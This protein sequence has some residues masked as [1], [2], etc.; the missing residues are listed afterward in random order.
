M[1]LFLVLSIFV[2][3][4]I[5]VKSQGCSSEQFQCD[6]GECIDKT[7]V[8]D[9]VTDC[10][11]ESLPGSDERDCPA[12]SCD[13]DEYQCPDGICI[14]SSFRCDGED[15]CSDGDDEQTC[16]GS[17]CSSEEYPCDNGYCIPSKFRCDRVEDCPDGSDEGTDRCTYPGCIDQKCDNGACYGAGERCDGKLD[18]RDGT[19]E[20]NCTSIRCQSGQ[21]QCDNGKCIPQA[22][23]CDVWNNCGDRSDEPD[24]CVYDDCPGDTFTCDNHVCVNQD[25]V[26]DGIDNC[27]DGTDEQGCNYDLVCLNNQWKCTNSS[28]CIDVVQICDGIKDCDNGEDESRP[29]TPDVCSSTRCGILSCDYRCHATLSGG[30]CYCNQGYQVADDMVSCE[31]FDECSVFGVC[32]QICENTV[33]SYKCECADGYVK[34]LHNNHIHC[35]AKPADGAPKLLYSVGKNILTYH[36]ETNAQDI[37]VTDVSDFPLGVDYHYTQGKL[38]WADTTLNKIMSSDM[39]GGQATTVL[40]VSIQNPE[41]VA[42]DW[43]ANNLYIIETLVS[44]IEV[45]NF[46]GSHRSSIIT[47]GIKSPR[48]LALDPTKGYMFFTDYHQDSPRLDR[49]YMDGSQ[50]YTLVDTEMGVPSGVAVDYVSSRV[51]WVDSKFDYLETVDYYGKDRRVVL[52]GSSSLPHPFDVTIFEDH[53]YVSD[54]TKLAILKANKFDGSEMETVTNTGGVKPMG[55]KAIHPVRQPQ[56]NNPCETQNGGCEHLCVLSHTSDNNGL[57]YSCLCDP[58]YVINVDGKTCS[59]VKSFLLVDNYDAIRGITVWRFQRPDAIL[60]ILSD[61]QYF[62]GTTADAVDG[63]IYFADAARSIV[64]RRFMNATGEQEDIINNR[65]SSIRSIAIDWTTKNLYVIDIGRRVIEVV[66]AKDPENLRKTIVSSG[67]SSPTGIALSPNQGY[68]VWADVARPAK[69]VKAWMDGTHQVPLVNTTLYSPVSV[70]IDLTSNYVYWIDSRFFRIERISLFGYGRTQ[71]STTQ[72][73]VYPSALTFFE[74]YVYWSD[75]RL[76][77]IYRLHELAGSFEAQAETVREGIP[78][79]YS[80]YYYDKDLQ[81]RYSSNQCTRPELPNGGCQKFCFPA[82]SQ[83][84]TCGCPDGFM[85]GVTGTTCVPD[86]HSTPP[87]PCTEYQF[88]CDNGRCVSSSYVCNGMDDCKDGSDEKDC[89]GTCGPYAFK[90]DNNQ[91]IY[92]SWKCDG[93]DDCGDNSDEVG[94]PTPRPCSSTS[95]QCDNGRCI[96]PTWVCDSTNDCGDG[97]DEKDCESQTC[98]PQQFACDDQRCISS[99]LRCNGYEDC[100]QGEDEK[101]CPP[102]SCDP[103]YYFACSNGVQCIGKS[104]KCDG[105]SDC[106]DGSDEIGCPTLH[107]GQCEND[108]FQC[109]SNGVCI[110]QTWYCDSRIDCDDGSDEPPTCPVKEC[111]SYEFR[112]DNNLCI[113]SI[114]KCNGYNNCGDGSDEKDCPTPPPTLPPPPCGFNEWECPGTTQCIEYSKVCNGLSDCPDALDEGDFCSVNRCNGYGCTDQCANLPDGP[115]CWCDGDGYQLLNDSK[116]CAD[117]DECS[118]HYCS[119]QCENKEGTFLCKCDDGYDLDIDKRTCKVTSESRIIMVSNRNYIYE[120]DVDKNY[121]RAPISSSNIMGTDFDWKTRKVYFADVQYGFLF[122]VFRNGTS[123]APVFQ[124]GQSIAENV[125]VDWVARNLYWCD[126]ELG[127]IEVARLDGSHRAILHAEN[128]TNPR[129]LALDPRQGAHVMF[130][131]D[132]GQNPRI[133]RSNMDGSSRVAIVTEQLYWPNGLTIDYPTY[134]VYFAD[135]KLD[136]IHRCDY[137]GG[138]R[139]EVLASDLIVRHPHSLTILE[140]FVYWADR[141]TRTVSRCNKWDGSKDQRVM[142]SGLSLPTSL[143]AFHP[144]RQPDAENPC[145][146]DPCS[147]LCLLGGIFPRGY[148]CACPI[149][150]ELTDTHTCSEVKNEFL[151]VSTPDR[152]FGISRDP[153]DQESDKIVPVTDIKNGIDVEHDDKEGYIYWAEQTVGDIRRV[154][155]D[156]TNRTIFAVLATI[157]SPNSL[158]IDWMS[159]NLYFTN[160]AGK[161]IEVIKMDSNKNG[162]FLHRTVVSNVGGDTGVGAPMGIAVDPIH[163]KLYWSDQGL[164]GVPPKISR[165]DMDGSELENII[166]GVSDIQ[167]IA[168]DIPEQRIYWAEQNPGVIKSANFDGSDVNTIVDNVISPMG[169]TVLDDYIYYSDLSLELIERAEKTNGNNQIT[170]RTDIQNVNSL[171]VYNRPVGKP[172]SCFVSNGGCEQFCFP[173]KSNFFQCACATGFKLNSDNKT[174]STYDSFVLVSQGNVIRGFDLSDG[175]NH[176][177]A[178]PPIGGP[179]T[180]TSAIDVDMKSGIVLWNNYYPGGSSSGINGLLNN[181]IYSLKTDGSGAGTAVFNGIGQQGITGFAIDWIAQNVYFTNAFNSETYLE[182]AQVSGKYRVI[183]LKTTEDLPRSLAVNPIKRYLYWSDYG[184]TP[185]IERALLDGSNRTVIAS[186]GIVHP[187]GLTIDYSTH[188]LFWAD[189][190]TSTIEKMSWD[191]SSRVIIRQGRNYPAPLGVAVYK[192]YIFWVDSKRNSLL[193]ASKDPSNSENPVVYRDGLANLNAV[194]VYDQSVHPDDPGTNPCLQNN[195]GCEQLCFAMPDDSKVC[196]C[197]YGKLGSDGTSCKTASDYIIYSTQQ[198]AESVH[199]DP[200]DHSQV[201]E[202]VSLPYPIALAYDLE[203]RRA[204]F[205]T[206][207]GSNSKIGYFSLED[208]RPLP[209]YI[210]TSG[211]SAAEGL[212]FDWL[213]KRLY[214]TDYTQDTISSVGIDGKNKTTLVTGLDRPRAIALDPCRGYMYWTDWGTQAKIERATLAGNVRTTIIGTS[215]YYP[216]GLTID[217]AEDVMYW[218]DAQPGYERIERSYLDGTNREMVLRSY[219][220]PFAITVL[221]QFVYWSDWSTRSIYRANK[222]DGGSVSV[223]RFGL[224][225]T[226]M[227]VLAV[228]TRAQAECIGYNPCKRYN[229]GCSNICTVGPDGASE[230]S[231]PTDDG[232]KYYLA[233]NE[234]ECIVDIG[235][236]RCDADRYTCPNGD[237]KSLSWVCDGYSDCISGTD[238]ADRVCADHQ[239]QSNQH[240][241]PSGRCIPIN[242]VCDHDNDCG[243]WS[244]ELGCPFPECEEGEFTCANYRCISQYYVCNGYDNCRDGQVSDEKDCPPISCAPEYHKCE[245]T[246]ICIKDDYLCDGDND[247]GDNSD[248]APTFCEN[249]ECD[250]DQFKCTDPPA[251]IPAHW[252]CDGYVDCDDS[253][254]ETDDCDHPAMTCPPGAWKCNNGK[255]ID[256]DWIC[257]G[258]D[259][260][261]DNSDEE[262]DCASRPCNDNDFKCESIQP[263]SN[264]CIPNFYVCDGYPDCSD[265]SDEL[266]D[267][268]ARNCSSGQFTCA[269]GVCISQ[270]YVCDHN[271]DCGDFSDEYDDCDYQPCQSYQ[272]T[273]ESGK[274]I[275]ASYQC[276]GRDDCGD[277]SDEEDCATEPPTCAPDEFMCEDGQCIDKSLVC[278]RNPD[279]DD[280]SDEQ[281]CGVN[282]C[283]DVISNQCAQKCIDTQTS[284]YCACNDGYRLMAD[285]KAC[286]DINEC[287]ETPWV[288]S[289]MCDNTDGSYY[290]KCGNGYLRE[291][292]GTCRQSSGIDP[293]LLFSNRYYIR[294]IATDGSDYELVTQGHDTIVALD[295]HYGDKRLFWTDVTRGLMESMNF[296]GSDRKVLFSREVPNGEGLAVEWVTRKLYWVDANLDSMFVS[297]LNG[298]N[299]RTIL[300]GCIDVNNTYCFDQPR[301]VVVHPKRGYVFWTDYGIVPYIARAGLNGDQA[302]A[303]ITERISWPNALTLDYVTE[304]L[305]WGDAHTDA[306]EYAYINGSNRKM[307]NMEVSPPHPF[308]MTFFESYIYWTDWNTLSLYKAH[309]LDAS[310]MQLMVNTTHRPY[311]V[312]I[313]HPYRQD[314]SITNPCG[315]NNGGCSHLCLMMPGGDNA[316]CQCPDGFSSLHQGLGYKCVP[317]CNSDQ[318]RCDSIEKCIPFIWKCDGVKDCPDGSDEPDS[319]PPR[320]C[321]PGYFQ[322]D[323]FECVLPEFRCDGSDDCGDGSDEGSFCQDY[324]CLPSQM[325]C[326]NGNCV[327]QPV[328]CDGTD[329]CGDGTDEDSEM[330]STRTCPGSDFTCDNGRCIPANWVCDV[331]DDCGDGSDEPL[332]VCTGPDHRCD[333][334]TEFSCQTTYRCIP[335][336]LLCNGNDDCYDNSDEADCPNSS[337]HPTGDFRCQ[338][339]QCIPLRWQCDG[340]DDCGDGSDEVSCPPRACTESEFRCANQNCIPGSWVCNQYDNCGDGS[341]EVGC[342]AKDCQEGYFECDSGHCIPSALTCDGDRDCNDASD[343]AECPPQFGQ[344]Y[345]PLSRFECDNHVCVNFNFRCDG[346]NDCG[347]GSDEYPS[348]CESID[349]DPPYYRCEK[350]RICLFETKFCDGHDD[351]GD[352]SDEAVDICQTTTPSAICSP[353]QFKCLN[354]KCISDQLICNDYDDCGDITDELGCHKGDTDWVCADNPCEQ[355]CTEIPS[356]NSQPGFYLCSCDNGFKVNPDDTHSCLDIDECI[357]NWDACPQRCRNSKGSYECQCLDG[358]EKAGA[359]ECSAKGF[360]LHIVADEQDV[361]TYDMENDREGELIDKQLRTQALDYAY[362]DGSTTVLFWTDTASA[363]DSNGFQK[364]KPK[365]I[366]T[367]MPYVD[368]TS[369]NYGSSQVLDIDGLQQ[370][371]GIAADWVAGNLYWTDAMA[372][373]ISVSLLDGRYR[374]ILFRKLDTPHAIALSPRDGHM[375]WTSL[376]S[377]P[378]V[379]RAHMDGMEMKMLDD[380]IVDYP[381]GVAIDY[382]NN[383]RLYICD[384]KANMIVSANAFGKDV[385]IVTR[386]GLG[387]PLSVEVFENSLYWT[388]ATDGA[389]Y[390]QDKFGRGVMTLVQEGFVH[391]ND[392]KVFNPYRYDNVSTTGCKPGACS[393]LCLLSPNS[394]T[395]ACPEGTN[396]K[397]GNARECDASLEPAKQ[398]PPVCQCRNGATCIYDQNMLPSCVCAPGFIGDNCDQGG[399]QP[400]SNSISGGAIAGIIIAVILLVLVLLAVAYVVHKGRETGGLSK[401]SISCSVPCPTNCFKSTERSQFSYDNPIAY[402]AE[403]NQVETS[404][405]VLEDKSE[406]S[407]SK[408][409]VGTS[410]TTHPAQRG[411]TN[412]NYYAAQKDVTNLVKNDFND[413]SMA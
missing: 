37:S 17:T 375:Y 270:Y 66:N 104:Y 2:S 319:C 83:S 183:L 60:P 195:G 218:V 388:S 373:T 173:V 133:E 11:G 362:I 141:E 410:E 403:N 155:I 100:R 121:L 153:S 329:D 306:I 214:F 340:W 268:P 293:Y 181:G 184:Q 372:G 200:D 10:R 357:Q 276:N 134:T 352:G 196:D 39:N 295:Y 390:R 201:F 48:G 300:T 280:K 27:G 146:G 86:P 90:C 271:N 327:N 24:T 161:S 163:A 217:F 284:F 279:C 367:L 404:T 366:R 249:K 246:N 16:P 224:S 230:C 142:I 77:A 326:N 189:D 322:C 70:A 350:T 216:N 344:N 210:V 343:E 174:C 89:N 131:T 258:L 208:T 106:R 157:G 339:H 50:I 346:Q 30:I 56:V 1:K 209:T 393:H 43:I 282:E 223:V 283:Q 120:L 313:V 413:D 111:A 269:N 35:K 380:I 376:G 97:S 274:C 7:W 307:L 411:I 222:Q 212:D 85:P 370:P 180:S 148:T 116:T 289:Q 356:A 152:I 389:I 25:F 3:T 87:P 324:P 191:G 341:D 234:R 238:E 305:Y 138:S 29:G 171:K 95:F 5:T 301:A 402:S 363:Y 239:C 242:Y 387:N 392:V 9:G 57:G 140:D 28:K 273:C 65:L 336:Y 54:W 384:E 395:C 320:Y 169:I 285:Q 118:L 391:P 236:D 162:A 332:D 338:N 49:A 193:R 151:V 386:G 264:G 99:N 337:C 360:S 58:G 154:H 139:A 381:T 371:N 156:G 303:I 277:G 244:D 243:D 103:S 202:P 41:Q 82:P 73:I 365:I 377:T 232:N 253:S 259:D 251:C 178:M 397:P 231:C 84:R 325:K 144:V 335:T 47:D 263:G 172:N 351:C 137:N 297:E 383:R 348:V 241:C 323:N 18:C 257:D 130:W 107:P 330:C 150:S 204:Y 176:I 115:L 349:C 215:L 267:C 333:A 91:C 105:A 255:C 345:C 117:I 408:D 135:A 361:K 15:D 296:D 6:S 355:T 168:L 74:D 182:V 126:Y 385:K 374:H 159:R 14:P 33:G 68:M 108:Q 237:C 287:D 94:C 262:Q 79:S 396:F 409:V 128:V 190:K 316:E 55:I 219:D 220:H 311:D 188:E 399:A 221:D 286:E 96:S 407:A 342:P 211:L 412:K 290:C 51:Y 170:L 166:T 158:A 331:D 177:D 261:G 92:I 378:G 109:Q 328:I 75:N 294:K 256:A 102:V 227:D 382:Q 32:E 175:D 186:S 34:E 149:G 145:D 36:L 44:R 143:H 26:C 194:A 379:Y 147:H 260:C 40:D 291:P 369:N 46:D 179:Y 185:K 165:C 125:A 22:F 400:V 80:M 132:W 317:N 45:C 8:C 368:G 203:D 308:A 21:F 278:D 119:Q 228:S 192:D 314:V 160:P 292:D 235:Q 23:V 136:F 398:L 358:Y 248:E 315:E 302:M 72:S 225:S 245:S 334:T 266:Q 69:I 127:T 299:K 254:D 272:F 78:H 167:H 67:L 206:Y 61:G 110:P 59:E 42:V 226:P 4:L 198:T 38:F 247:C 63:Y 205:L 124:S 405:D 20:F 288:C 197:S 354:G 250:D 229:G 12:T 129:G 164:G 52:T 123:R 93:D 64:Q 53:V 364:I 275:Y 81:V 112:C 281:R 114:Y 321:D 359:D 187:N 98:N 310:N 207:Q 62:V 31:D 113:S 122:S 76:N 309:A 318:Y 88:A 304:R 213:H 101:D 347:D 401:P 298:T 233:N 13:D 406:A 19:D 265:A 252:Y 353:G 394:Y 240:R 71:L 312:H 199:I